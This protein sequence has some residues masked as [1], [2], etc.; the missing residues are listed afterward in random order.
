MIKQYLSDKFD[1]KNV[2]DLSL[3]LSHDTL[4]I[5]AKD[6][7]DAVIG[8]QLYHFSDIEELNKIIEECDLFHSGIKQGK[9]FLH[10]EIFSI[11][12]GLLFDPNAKEQYL[13]FSTDLLAQKDCLTFSDSLDS[14]NFHLIGG[15]E[16]EIFNLFDA[17]I[18]GLRLSH[19]GLIGLS[20]LLSLKNEFI[21][22][23]VFVI[24]EQNHIYLAAFAS[25]DL[26]L[27]N[28]FAVAD[29]AELLKYLFI[30]FQ[31]L[32]FSRDYCKV[33]IIGDLSKLHTR[34]E[35]LENYFK[36]V[37]E[38]DPT[39]NINYLPGAES[40]KETKSLDAYWTV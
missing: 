23:E 7:N 27:F 8:S 15:V 5:M 16:K 20:Y 9:L 13:N 38:V 29:E 2:S 30:V 12:P 34:K 18:P 32:K 25:H 21:G 28:R 17:K 10:N 40:I 33:N 22:Q 39:T 19:G 36:H 35:N 1:T 6:H 24:I 4:T 3:L 37:I 31:Q 11:V 26:Q 14:N